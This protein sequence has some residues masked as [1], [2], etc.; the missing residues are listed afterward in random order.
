MSPKYFEYKDSCSYFDRLKTFPFPPLC[1]C[2]IFMK[3]FARLLATTCMKLYF[4][5]LSN[6]MDKV[7][8]GCRNVP[9]WSSG[10][11]SKLKL[12]KWKRR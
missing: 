5:S 12:A 2:N 11:N 7:L 3:S 9:L 4:Q 10:I 1:L 8:K 6:P